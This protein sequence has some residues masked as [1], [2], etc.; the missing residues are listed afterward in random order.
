V[1]EPRVVVDTGPLGAFLVKGETHRPWAMAQFQ[2]LPAPFLTCEAVLTETFFLV[3]KLPHETAKFGSMSS[4][5]FYSSCTTTSFPS[6]RAL[7][8]HPRSH[9]LELPI[10]SVSLNLEGLKRKRVAESR[11]P[12]KAT[13]P[14]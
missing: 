7:P 12:A 14:R 1:P 10:A 2:R 4:K 9:Q 6:R 5:K 3:R 11:A 13:Q 8:A